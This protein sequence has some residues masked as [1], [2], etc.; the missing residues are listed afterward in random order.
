MCFAFTWCTELERTYLEDSRQV[1]PD[2]PC[3]LL[4]ERS[5]QNSIVRIVAG[6]AE[7]CKGEQTS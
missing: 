6:Y 7:N 4:A 1:P 3:R 5:L 2:E